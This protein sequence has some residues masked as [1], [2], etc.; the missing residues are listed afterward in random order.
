MPGRAL[1]HAWDVLCGV[2]QEGFCGK[3][4]YKTIHH[5]TLGLSGISDL[6]PPGVRSL[7]QTLGVGGLRAGAGAGQRCGVW[8]ETMF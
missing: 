7:V 2:F 4:G 6:Q 8:E 1:R 3:S 5:R